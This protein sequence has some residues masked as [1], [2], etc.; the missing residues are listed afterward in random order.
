MLE[1]YFLWTMMLEC[2]FLWQRQY[3]VK[4]QWCWSVEPSCS[5]QAQSLLVKLWAKRCILPKRIHRQGDK[6]N[7]ANRRARDDEF[8]VDLSSDLELLSSDLN[9]CIFWDLG[10]Q[11][12]LVCFAW[13][14]QLIPYIFLWL[15]L[16]SRMR[17]LKGKYIIWWTL[18]FATLQHRCLDGDLRGLAM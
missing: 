1:C 18:R 13:W 17:I 14:A 3:L 12:D 7:S 8:L 6:K 11:S 4:L 16:Y 2:Y 5:W 10:L 15:C 9:S